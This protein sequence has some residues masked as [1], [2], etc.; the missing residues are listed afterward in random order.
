VEAFAML[1]LRTSRMRIAAS[2]PLVEILRVMFGI[3]SETRH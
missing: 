3:L 1:L 2:M